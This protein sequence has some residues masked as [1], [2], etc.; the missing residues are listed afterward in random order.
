MEDLLKSLIL[1]IVMFGV[2]YFFMIRPQKKQEEEKREMI[3]N[4]VVGNEIV[5][6]GGIIGK[7]VVAKEDILTIETSTAKSRFDI[8]RWAVGSVLEK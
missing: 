2:L 3:K 7:V 5:T 6:I 1:P 8:Y 4:I